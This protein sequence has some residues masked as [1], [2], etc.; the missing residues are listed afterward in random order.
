MF[1]VKHFYRAVLRD[2]KGALDR[3][4]ESRNAKAIKFGWVLFEQS[5]GVAECFRLHKWRCGEQ[6]AGV[7]GG[8][9]VLYQPS[10]RMVD[11]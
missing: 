5:K 2:F 11:R 6:Q 10:E 7:F 9:A 4:L 1:W 8:R 3:S